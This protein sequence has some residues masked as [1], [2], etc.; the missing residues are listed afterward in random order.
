ME[1]WTGRRRVPSIGEST[2]TQPPAASSWLALLAASPWPIVPADRR[3]PK[4]TSQPVYSKTPPTKPRSSHC[5][6]ASSRLPT[7]YATQAAPTH[8]LQPPAWNKPTQTASAFSNPNKNEQNS[9]CSQ[10]FPFQET[11]SKQCIIK[12]KK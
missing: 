8:P 12:K 5:G 3:T 1:Q 6:E 2:Q 4:V 9:Q 7:A 10:T 11:K